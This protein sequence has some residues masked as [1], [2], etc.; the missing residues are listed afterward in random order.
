GGTVL[1]GAM[2]ALYDNARW[3]VLEEALRLA[4]RGDG[5]T[6]FDLADAATGRQRD[7]TF[8]NTLDASFVI[9]CN[10]GTAVPSDDQIL[11]T[12]TRWATDF[13]LFGGY[14]AGGLYGCR[15]WDAPRHPLATPTAPGAPPVLV[16]GT[17]HDPATPY[18]GAVELTAALG[19][20][21]LLTWEG[22]GHTA[23]LRS[24][25]VDKI[26][27]DY[28]VTLTVPVGERRCAA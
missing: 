18:Q 12:A 26:V 15:F 19:S 16:I 20:G 2:S 14:R 24:P 27:E 10:D 22:E 11:S 8:P 5:T 17:A 9:G 1:L 4:R 25:C 3:P 7:G 28:L 23:Y 21:V 13:P 6:F